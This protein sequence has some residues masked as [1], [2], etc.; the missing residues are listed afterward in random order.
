[1]KIEVRVRTRA[2]VEKIELKS[3]PRLGFETG[4]PEIQVYTA[5][6]KAPPVDG[7]ANQAVVD[8]LSGHFKIAKK[9]VRIISGQTTR[10]KYFEIKKPEF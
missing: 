8:L 3:Q 4:K 7:R 2:K 9:D 1:M 5:W 6:V 10:I